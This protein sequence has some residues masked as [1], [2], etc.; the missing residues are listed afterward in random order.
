MEEKLKCRVCN[1]RFNHLGSHLWH[2]HKLLARD[3]KERFGLPYKM[4]LV[5][6]HIREK[7]QEANARWKGRV[8]KNLLKGGKKYQFKKG[9]SG[10]RRIS[11]HERK[12][13]LKRIIGVNKN[14]AKLQAC[15]VCKI[16][17][18]HMESHL[19]QVHS[20]IKINK[21]AMKCA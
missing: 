3:Y 19:Y 20:L 10:Q 7:Q 13:I 9:R 11:E 21:G 6:E 18:N 14:H 8:R 4:G 17:F 1:K 2:K 15:P 16:K 5:S 12:V